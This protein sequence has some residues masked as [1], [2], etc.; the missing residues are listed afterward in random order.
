V[1]S[2]ALKFLE[3]TSCHSTDFT[4]TLFR[5]VS[6]ARLYQ[7]SFETHPYR[8]LAFTNGA[9]NGLGDAAAQLSQ[10]VVSF[11]FFCSSVGQTRTYVARRQTTRQASHIRSLA[12]APLLLLRFRPGLSTYYLDR[13]RIVADQSITQGPFIGRWNFF[14]EKTFPL[15][16]VAGTGKVSLKALSKRVSADQ[17]FM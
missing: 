7:Q 2:R 17:V 5:M 4:I 1:R 15:R 16:T 11:G 9:L 13:S 12:H 10:R 8:T 6:I 3:V 14:L